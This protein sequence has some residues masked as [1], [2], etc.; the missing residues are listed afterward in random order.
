VFANDSSKEKLN[1]DHAA[2]ANHPSSESKNAVSAS[3]GQYVTTAT[4]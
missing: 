3:N 4:R 1:S 2:H